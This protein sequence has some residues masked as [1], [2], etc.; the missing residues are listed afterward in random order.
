MSLENVF[1]IN[2]APPVLIAETQVK[3]KSRPDDFERAPIGTEE[4]LQSHHYGSKDLLLASTIEDKIRQYIYKN[5]IKMNE[6]FRDYDR[7]NCGFITQNQFWAGFKLARV[8]LENPE[9]VVIIS[10]YRHLDGRLNYR[11][12]CKNIETIF[13]KDNLESFPMENI[14]PPSREWLIQVFID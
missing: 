3:S 8:P 9:V 2:I 5:R 13:T 1:Y 12:F 14:K 7:H 10:K 11:L 4:V 6:F